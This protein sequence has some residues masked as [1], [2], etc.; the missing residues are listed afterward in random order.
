[1]VRRTA[2][3]A[4]V[5]PALVFSMTACGGDGGGEKKGGGSGQ[6]GGSG[7]GESAAKSLS[8]AELK[9][10]LL[11]TGDVS[12]YK[13][14]GTGEDPLKNENLPRTQ[15]KC[16]P[17]LDSFNPDSKQKRKAYVGASVMKGEMSTGQTFD[18]VLLASY[19]GQDAESVLSD[20]K[21][22][23]KTCKEISGDG[24]GDKKV[25]IEEAQA[26]DLGDDSVRFLMKGGASKEG[27]MSLTVVRS[28]AN[29]SSFMSLSLS[30]KQAQGKEPGVPPAVA[31]K[32]VA[33]VEAAAKG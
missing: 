21:S 28:G 17:V 5:V 1:M 33:K 24:S 6:E 15:S 20:L 2:A 26:P 25:A 7:G 4:V 32:Q 31:K 18:Q 9:K 29:T 16:Q 23:L 8:K 11:K 12:G 22:S 13:V 3:A 10:A 14:R 27:A 30:G 19:E